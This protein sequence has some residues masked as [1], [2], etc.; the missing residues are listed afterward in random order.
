[1]S[2]IELGAG[3]WN[4]GPVL[5]KRGAAAAALSPAEMA[6]IVAYLFVSRHFDPSTGDGK[7]GQRLVEKKGCLGCH[8]VQG[9]GSRWAPDLATS[10]VVGSAAAQVAVMW[11]HARRMQTEARRQAL[12]LPELTGPELADITNYLAGLGRGPAR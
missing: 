4:H 6:D 10:N 7:R 12:A 1:V 8:A 2:L 9:K 11:R 5:K 3:L